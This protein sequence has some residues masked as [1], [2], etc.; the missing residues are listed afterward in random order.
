MAENEQ[1]VISS[2][3]LSVKFNVKILLMHSP[4]FTS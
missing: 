3:Y 2:D 1:C 4:F